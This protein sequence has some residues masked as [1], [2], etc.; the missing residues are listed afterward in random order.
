MSRIGR[1]PIAVPSGVTVALAEDSVT[2]TG[3]QGTLARTL[4]AGSPSARTVTS[5]SS[6]APTTSGATGPCTA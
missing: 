3:P 5:W 2:V 6:S 1:S 4:P